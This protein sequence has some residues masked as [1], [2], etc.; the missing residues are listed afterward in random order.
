MNGQIFDP[1]NCVKNISTRQFELLRW[2]QGSHKFLKCKVAIPLPPQPC[3]NH[4]RGH[5]GKGRNLNRGQFLK[6]IPYFTQA[7]GKTKFP[8]LSTSKI[9]FGGTELWSN[10]ESANRIAEKIIPTIKKFKWNLLFFA[11]V[12]VNRSISLFVFSRFSDAPIS[13]SYTHLTLPTKA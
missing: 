11:S 3:K 6:K 13:V 12:V 4:K 9:H 7:I 8:E 1:D 5:G 2:H 10:F